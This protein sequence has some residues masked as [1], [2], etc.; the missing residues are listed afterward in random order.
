MLVLIQP[1]P[2]GRQMC[3]QQDHC[4]NVFLLIIIF[5]FYWPA[6]A[7]DLFCVSVINLL[8]ISVTC[9]VQVIQSFALTLF[10]FRMLVKMVMWC[11][12]VINHSGRSQEESGEVLFSHV[13]N[14]LFYVLSP[15]EKDRR[16]KVSE[17]ESAEEAV[18]TVRLHAEKELQMQL[19]LWECWLRA[20]EIHGCSEC[21]TDERLGWD[22]GRWSATATPKENDQKK[23]KNSENH[24]II[25]LKNKKMKDNF[26]QHLEQFQ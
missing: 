2:A 12:H 20:V 6:T 7:K 1:Q 3:L 15:G 26:I 21:V 22:G 13:M 18:M 23:K 14:V 5:C 8:F 16:R 10:T 24:K 19:L 17:A 11:F 25:F 4:R 9:W